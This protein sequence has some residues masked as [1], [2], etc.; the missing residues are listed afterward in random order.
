MNNSTKIY[1]Y[2]GKCG[3]RPSH[4]GFYCLK[5]ANYICLDS[6]FYE[7]NAAYFMN[8][9]GSS[10]ISEGVRFDQI[11]VFTLRIQTDRPE[12]TV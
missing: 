5:G 9:G 11:S 10:I 2:P 3:V 1:L 7:S 4:F 8:Q 6:E 12:Q